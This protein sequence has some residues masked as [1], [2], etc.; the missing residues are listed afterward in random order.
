MVN[1]PGPLQRN[2]LFLARPQFNDKEGVGGWF[3]KVD[4]NGGAAET[5]IVAGLSAL[6]QSNGKAFSDSSSFHSFVFASAM[7]TPNDV[8]MNNPNEGF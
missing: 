8:D 2:S 7:T 3:G 5:Q 1:L 4:M 6:G